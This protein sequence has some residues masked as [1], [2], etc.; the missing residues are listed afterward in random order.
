M[1]EIPLEGAYEGY[2]DLN[3]K[4]AAPTLEARAA[5][6]ISSETHIACFSGQTSGQ[7]IR[8]RP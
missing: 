1:N 2:I 4:N 3:N 7:G 8:C 5:F 6:F